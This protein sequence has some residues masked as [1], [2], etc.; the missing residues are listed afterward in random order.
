MRIAVVGSRS[1]KSIDLDQYLADEHPSEIISGGA[2][3]ID[4]LAAQWAK[5]RGIPT[6]VFLPDYRR[7]GSRA[8]LVRN[9]QIVKAADKVIAL[10]DGK[11]TGTMHTVKTARQND[12]PVVLHN[13]SS[14]SAEDVNQPTLF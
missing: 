11:S 3:G 12:K 7:Y 6:T 9:E 13:L 14:K 4:T 5:E 2:I 1:I 8:P 10:W